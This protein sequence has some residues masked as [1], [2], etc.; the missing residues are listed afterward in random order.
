MKKIILILLIALSI[1]GCVYNGE[2]ESVCCDG[3]EGLNKIIDSLETT[4][5]DTLILPSGTIYKDRI[6]Y[7]DSIIYQDKFV[8]V[9]RIDTICP[10]DTVII[11]PPVIINSPNTFSEVIGVNAS[12]NGV[13]DLAYAFD[14]QRVFY[15]LDHDLH[16]KTLIQKFPKACEAKCPNIGGADAH[17]NDGNAAWVYRM[18][19][20]TKIDT[21]Y[22]NGTMS[23]E[24][25][26]KT[27]TLD[28]E[29][30]YYPDGN[31]GIAEKKYPNK[32][33]SLADMDGK[34][35]EY[36]KKYGKLLNTSMSQFADDVD[37][38]IAVANEPHG[39]P[40]Y[41]TIT[42]WSKGMKEGLTGSGIKLVSQDLQSTGVDVFNGKVLFNNIE[43]IDTSLFDVIQVHSYVFDKNFRLTLPPETDSQKWM[44]PL[45]EMKDMR[46]YVTTGQ[47]LWLTEFGY[48]SEALGEETQSAYI[49]RT[50]VLAMRYG[51]SKAHVYSIVDEPV[52]PFKNCG[53]V[54]PNGVSKQSY[55]D[56]ID[57]IAQYGDYYFKE[58]AKDGENGDF[59][60]V[61]TDGKDLLTISWNIADTTPPNF[62]IN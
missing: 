3:I 25:R 31:G 48:D 40:D 51:F 26:F 22:T 57:I 61:F 32:S 19:D 53:L 47:A 36:G 11:T 24:P 27:I 44:S 55:D 16:G 46:N 30:I 21:V 15:L 9:D 35:Y 50:I 62:K 42:L 12:L 8:Y 43:Y 17:W 6:V 34:P 45:Q 29:T 20:Y 4:K 59:I 39:S 37:L 60:Y 5:V 52:L 14:N 1:T 54:Y 7:K 10:D 18:C 23:L 49:I 13:M 28:L 41:E 56:L 2:V 38:Y 58:V 33:L